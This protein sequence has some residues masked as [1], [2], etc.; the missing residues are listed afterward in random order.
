VPP[1]L[2]VNQQGHTPGLHNSGRE[3]TAM[4]CQLQAWGSLSRLELRTAQFLA[5]VDPAQG[6]YLCH[7]K[8]TRIVLGIKV[9]K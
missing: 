3:G 9:D 1:S 8:G 5:Q 7:P 4:R 6:S 2:G